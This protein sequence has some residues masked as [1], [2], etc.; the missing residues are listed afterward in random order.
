MTAWTLSL[1]QCTNYANNW[2]KFS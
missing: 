2:G 1:C